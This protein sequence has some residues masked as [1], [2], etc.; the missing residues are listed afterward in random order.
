MPRVFVRLDGALL[1]KGVWW[2][3]KKL[4]IAFVDEKQL[5]GNFLGKLL[6]S[7][8]IVVRW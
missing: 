4:S 8:V 5:K 2:D 1:L 7:P 3:F 6:P